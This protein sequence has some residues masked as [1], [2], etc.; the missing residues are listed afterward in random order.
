M[1][2]LDPK[3]IFRRLGPSV[4]WVSAW[5]Q[6]RTRVSK[7]SN[8]KLLRSS[9]KGI[10][11]SCT[12]LRSTFPLGCSYPFCG[13]PHNT[14]TH[15]YLKKKKFVYKSEVEECLNFFLLKYEKQ[16]A[17]VFLVVILIK[18]RVALCARTLK[19][20]SCC[21]LIFSHGAQE[22]GAPNRPLW[23][24]PYLAERASRKSQ[25]FRTAWVGPRIRWW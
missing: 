5:N 8:R 20:V 10:S 6:A 21:H 12:H 4:D 16:K 25:E 23:S 17:S 14:H 13:L 3:Q 22:S 9:F 1:D 11:V 15:C 24:Q 2:F 18:S 7:A 19:L